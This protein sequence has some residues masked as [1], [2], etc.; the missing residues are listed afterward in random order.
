MTP[1][2]PI[3][4]DNIYKFY[5]SCGLVL[6]IA[7]LV[8]FVYVQDSTN[9]KILNWLTS[10]SQFES[11]GVIAEYEKKQIELYNH[12]IEITT[13]DKKLFHK[14]LSGIVAISLWISGFGFYKWEKT[15]QPRDDLILELRIMQLE[16]ELKK[17]SN[18]KFQRTRYTRR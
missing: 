11:D 15:I 14:I 4:T 2:I 9:E 10:I 12:L 16:K 8:A 6:L 1:N 7:A 3:P 13:D 17:S 18:N 5:A